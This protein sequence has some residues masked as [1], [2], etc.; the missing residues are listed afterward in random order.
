[1][2]SLC[3]AAL[4]FC[5]CFVMLWFGGVAMSRCRS[6]AKGE[7]EESLGMRSDINRLLHNQ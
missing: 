4:M 3:R 5:C 6:K 7:D 1:M 2:L